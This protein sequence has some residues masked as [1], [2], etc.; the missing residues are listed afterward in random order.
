MLSIILSAFDMRRELPRTLRTLSRE[1][2]R[3]V[4]AIDYE[5]IVVENGS[6]EPVSEALVRSF[7]LEFRHL[8]VDEGLVSPALAMN[9]AAEV[10]EGD[11]LCVMNDGARMASPGLIARSLEPYAIHK[12]AVTTT[13]AWHLGPDVQMRSVLAGYDQAVEDR[14]LAETP[15]EQDG[16]QL[17]SISVLAG[18][19]RAGWFRPPSESNSLF[20][21]RRAFE[22]VGGLD[23]RFTSP[24]GGFLA[25]DFF[26]RVWALQWAQPVMVLGEGTFHQVHGG[27]ATNAPVG[28]GRA[29]LQRM[30]EEYI[31]IRGEAYR[32]P[33]REALCYGALS[34]PA[35]RFLTPRPSRR[36]SWPRRLRERLGLRRSTRA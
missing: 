14:L 1:Y 22:S 7:G 24:G 26:K 16:Y 35:R 19:S 33:T 2:Q 20:L 15:W 32:A 9:R 30:E 3:G 18:S 21:T 4:E 12:D 34:E 17:F 31:A 25:L 6:N 8:Y 10:A 11:L 36:A 27:V 28:E 13:L 5:V 29:R 23:E